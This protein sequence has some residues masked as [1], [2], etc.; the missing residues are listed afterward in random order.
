M[1][2]AGLERGVS[3]YGK[4]V[5]KAVKLLL[6]KITSRRIWHHVSASRVGL[7]WITK[8][9]YGNKWVAIN[10]HLYD[11][12]NDPLYIRLTGVKGRDFHG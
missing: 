10:K 7:R 11:S 1:V 9:W 8:Y 6:T 5:S 2:V 3:H 4:T 12:I